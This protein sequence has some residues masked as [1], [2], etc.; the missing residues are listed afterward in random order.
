MPKPGT[1]GNAVFAEPAGAEV[2]LD[3]VLLLDVTVTATD[4]VRGAAPDIGPVE[5]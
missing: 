5:S 3:G 1:S 2:V 4:R